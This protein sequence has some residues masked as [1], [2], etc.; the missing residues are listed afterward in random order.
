MFELKAAAEMALQKAI[1]AHHAK[2]ETKQNWTR[3]AACIDQVIN[4]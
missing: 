2:E 1:G 3:L 4:E